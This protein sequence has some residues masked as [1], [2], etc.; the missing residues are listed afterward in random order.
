VNM[1]PQ[2]LYQTLLKATEGNNG[3][4]MAAQSRC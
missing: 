3:Q 4:I 2:P 1:A